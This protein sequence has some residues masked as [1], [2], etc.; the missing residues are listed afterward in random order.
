MR[1]KALLSSLVLVLLSVTLLAA[2][3][4]L[5]NM[6][7]R[8]SDDARRLSDVAYDGFRRRD[9]GNR[10]D[11]EALY[12]TIEFHSA[13]ELFQRMI[14]DNRPQSELRDSVY[15]LRDRLTRMDRYGFGRQ[16]RSRMSV[17]LQ[18]IERQL[19][20][21]TRSDRTPPSSEDDD[22]RQG[23]ETGLLTWSGRVDDE[24]I[25]IVRGSRVNVRVV[26]GVRVQDD[27]YSFESPLPRNEVDLQVRKR[28]GRGSVDL[29]EEPT[30]QNDYTAMIR[31]RD[32][33]SGS[34]VY[35]LEVSW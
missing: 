6:A 25:L 2:D 9:R 17:L 16:E 24:V 7:A 32:N 26:K 28:R 19:G 8:L 5:Q 34:D 18:N 3:S 4:E 35:E 22:W 1:Q 27:D 12:A 20:G 21:P 33:R 31:I 14:G 11:V 15:V 29:I 30:R 13:T 23:G 10:A